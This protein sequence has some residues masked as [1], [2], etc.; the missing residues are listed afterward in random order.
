[1]AVGRW[2]PRR[3]AFEHRAAVVG[4]DRDDAARRAAALAGDAPPGR[5]ARAAAPGASGSCSPARARSAPG[6]AAGCTRRSR[7]S[8]RRSTRS[9]RS[10]IDELDGCS[11]PGDGRRRSDADRWYAAGAVR[12]RGGAVPAAGVARGAARTSWP[13]TRSASSPPP[14]SPACCRWTTPAALVAARGR[15]MQ[16]CRR[17]GR[18]SPSDDRGRGRLAAPG[19]TVAIAAVNGPPRWS[20]PAT[21]TR[22]PPALDGAARAGAPRLRVSHAFH[23][24]LV[25]PMLDA[26]RARSPPPSS[27]AHRRS[28]WSR[29]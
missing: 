2:P 18:W 27:T 13:A 12:R 25:E 16:G 23:S 28:R 4:A 9:A 21:A 7:C 5:G 26:F 19:R 22:W 10:S 3:A 6:W 17:A 1:M 29:P 24:P 20:S 15:L 11:G 8:P 14:T